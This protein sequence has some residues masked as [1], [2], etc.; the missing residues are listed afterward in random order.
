ME[1]ILHIPFGIGARF[2]RRTIPE[3]LRLRAVVEG[4]V[5]V[6]ST[7]SDANVGVVNL[8]IAEAEPNFNAPQTGKRP[9]LSALSADH[10]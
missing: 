10:A 2:D 7:P 4:S 9:V 1:R 5:A 8:P 6:A 3:R